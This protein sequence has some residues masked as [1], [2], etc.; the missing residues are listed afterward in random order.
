MKKGFTLIELLAVIAILGVI[1]VITTP[2]ITTSI[3]VSKDRAYDRQKEMI[4]RAAEEYVNENAIGFN[5][6]KVS[7]QTLKNEGYLKDGDI[8]N[9]KN[10]SVMN[11][12]VSISKS[13][14]KYTYTYNESC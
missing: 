5:A 9:P 13:G 14:N 10:N 11:G 6:N 7:I 1:V 12:C 4:V 3:S 8:K 2:V